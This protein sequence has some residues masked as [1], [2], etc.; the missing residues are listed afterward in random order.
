MVPVLEGG[1]V[2]RLGEVVGMD[3]GRCR[4]SIADA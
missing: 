3:V 1:E 2:G 4:C